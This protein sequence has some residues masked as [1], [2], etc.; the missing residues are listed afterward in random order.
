M[1][2]YKKLYKN[3]KFK[4]LAPTWNEEIELPDGSYSRS[5]IQDYF[6]YIIK[7]HGTVTHNPSIRIYL[8]KIENRITFKIKRGYY[9]ELLMTKTMK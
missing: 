4:I 2:K 3:N 8:N 6:E 7:K 9:F 5:D 1:E